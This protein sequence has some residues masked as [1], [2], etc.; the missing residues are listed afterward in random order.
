MSDRLRSALSNVLDGL[1]PTLKY[2][3]AWPYRVVSVTMTGAVPAVPVTVKVDATSIDPGM[4]DLMGIVVWPGPSGGLCV[5]AIGSLVRVAFI[6]GDPAQPMIVGVDPT[7]VQQSI[8]LGDGSAASLLKTS[9]YTQLVSALTTLASS[10][11]SATS[12][13]NVAAAG[14]ALQTSLAALPAV[15]GTTLVSAT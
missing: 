11:A 14:A 1:L 15:P 4:P 3:V 8:T 12:V 10:L 2:Y 6:A 5:P 7:A 9:S 13:A